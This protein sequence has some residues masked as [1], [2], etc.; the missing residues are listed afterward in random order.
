MNLLKGRLGRHRF[1]VMLVHFPSGLYPFSMVMDGI[2]LATGNPAFAFAGLCS[3]MGAVSTSIVAMVYG[4]IDFLQI[5]AQS[6]AWKT[7]GLH[8]V[9][10]VS[11]WMVYIVQL[12]YRLNHPDVSWLYVLITG[13][14][15]TG[16]IFSNYLGAELI[17]KHRVG[18]DKEG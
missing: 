5:D 18:I 15:T 9:L 13:L 8:A 2:F 3:L 7:A 17:V 4:V 6:K 10:N 11:W 1:H 12:A 14:T 16:L